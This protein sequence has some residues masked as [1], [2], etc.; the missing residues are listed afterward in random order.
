MSDLKVGVIQQDQETRDYF[1]TAQGRLS[2]YSRIRL[3]QYMNHLELKYDPAKTTGDQMRTS[4]IGHCQANGIEIPHITQFL[5]MWYENKS[6]A[7]QLSKQVAEKEDKQNA[8]HAVA[9]DA[10]YPSNFFQLKALAR[11]NGMDMSGNPNKAEIIAFLDG[12]KNKADS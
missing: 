12:K 11:D 5:E 3:Q 9:V 10:E 4:I 6:K 2:Q 7:P 8:I 1:A